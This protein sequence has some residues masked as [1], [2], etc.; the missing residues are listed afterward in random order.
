[1][2]ELGLQTQI[3]AQNPC[4]IDI[5]VCICECYRDPSGNLT[6]VRCT[7]NPPSGFDKNCFQASYPD[8]PG[9]GCASAIS[10][11]GYCKTLAP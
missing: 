2:G 5:G 3:V 8:C 7:G 1:M 9:G 6:S 10:D 11:P 4:R